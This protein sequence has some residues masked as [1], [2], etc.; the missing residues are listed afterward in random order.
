MNRPLCLLR[1]LHRQASVE[2]R[3]KTLEIL[4]TIFTNIIACPSAAKYRRIN[5]A[6]VMWERHVAPSFFLFQFIEWLEAIG[7]VHDAEHSLLQF[8]GDELSGVI[9]AREEVRIL[10]EAYV[11]PC[12]NES[13]N[14]VGKGKQLL[15]LLR[16][17]AGLADDGSQGNEVPL[18]DKDAPPA[19]INSEVWEEVKSL[20]YGAVLKRV[21]ERLGKG[22]FASQTVS[23]PPPSLPGSWAWPSLVEVVSGLSLSQVE[24][25]FSVIEAE[26]FSVYQHTTCG[27]A[28]LGALFKESARRRVAE[29]HK[30]DFSSS[31]ATFAN[32]NAELNYVA[33]R[34]IADIASC[35]EQVAVLEEAQGMVRKDRLEA[36]RLLRKFREDADITYLHLLKEEWKGQLKAAK[37][38][39]G[40]P[41]VYLQ[42]PSSE[43]RAE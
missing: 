29:R 16:I 12:P 6:S 21:S 2:C 33:T 36:R 14:D 11:V 13:K 30:N 37:E 10:F 28:K 40:K 38:K 20:L 22:S 39:H 9:R 19:C 43:S 23:Q 3:R 8:S 27:G 35:M 17:V 24:E 18:Q 5:M 34:L 41:F 4:D 32:A 42:T 31:D 15:P 25:D 7:F 1:L 26:L